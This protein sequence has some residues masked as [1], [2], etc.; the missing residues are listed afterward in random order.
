MFRLEI[1][2]DVTNRPAASLLQQQQTKSVERK[3]SIDSTTL[4]QADTRSIGGAD[5]RSLRSYTGAADSRSHVSFNIDNGSVKALAGSICAPRYTTIHSCH[6]TNISTH[7][8]CVRK[9]R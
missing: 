5:N 2:A 6:I 8:V 4:S 9:V 3:N 1:R 7:T